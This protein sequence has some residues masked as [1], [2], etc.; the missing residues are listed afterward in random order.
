MQQISKQNNFDVY[1]IYADDGIT[2]AAFVP[3][4]GGV[5]SSI[6]L[7][8]QGNAREILFQHTH[9]WER[10]NQHLPGGLPFIFPI[11]A[12]IERDRVFGNYLYDGHLYNL[13]IHGFAS[14]QAWECTVI[15]TD[16]LRL[17]LTDNAETLK[18]YPFNFRVELEYKINA[19]SLICYQT[20]T[21][22]GKKAMPYY[23]GFHPY[24]LT[25]QPQAEKAKVML[26]YKPKRRFLCNERLTDVI[27]EQPLFK[28]PAS[29]AD[30]QINEQLTQLGADKN[31][32]LQYPDGFE[33]KMQASGVED[34]N[35]F[36]YVQ[37][38]TQAEQPFICVEPWMAFPNA[39]NSVFGVR[40]LASGQSEKGILTL[41]N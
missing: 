26:V 16:A 6:I 3:E 5:A 2:Q 17:T 41:S 36:S 24:F 35:M 28:V 10:G 40:W 19:G 9:F 23:A 8:F 20:Y 1:H 29:V 15:A 22:T 34:V 33:L 7:P 27:G 38:Y 25:P 12:R 11:C 37:L 39:L 18:Q 32:K 31:I 13:P 4:K 14:H 30:P 21:N